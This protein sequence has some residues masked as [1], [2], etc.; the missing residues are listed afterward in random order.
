MDSQRRHC[1][2]FIDYA[3]LDADV[4]D[5]VH[6]LEEWKNKQKV[7][8][9][10]F[11]LLKPQVTIRP[12]H[13]FVADIQQMMDLF[14]SSTATE[15]NQD[16]LALGH[17]FSSQA[18]VAIIEEKRES[19][20]VII[21]T[22]NSQSD[23]FKS[24]NPSELFKL[25]QCYIEEIKNSK[26][27]FAFTSVEFSKEL[28]DSCWGIA[29]AINFSF[30]RP[31]AIVT[32]NPNA[33][34]SS[35]LEHQEAKQL[36]LDRYGITIN[37]QQKSGICLFSLFD[38][39]DVIYNLSPAAVSG[40]L[41][42]FS[43]QVG[44]ILW[45]LPPVSEVESKRHLYVPIFESFSNISFIANTGDDQRKLAKLSSYYQRYNIQLLG[46]IFGKKRIEF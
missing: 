39:V 20:P 16:I 17:S 41:A 38:F 2:T 46:I 7:H 4:E 18:P 12:P 37:Y 32:E 8:P 25:A 29:S 31:V 43:Q 13:R 34:F 6:D 42:E 10:R 28:T 9:F 45:C 3:H 40:F 24:K 33:A 5:V 44:T 14:D 15:N 27:H 36:T 26:N 1:E 23:Y 35:F 22:K 30:N 11:E 21:E 19:K